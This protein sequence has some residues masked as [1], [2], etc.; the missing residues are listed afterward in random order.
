LISKEPRAFDLQDLLTDSARAFCAQGR[1]R[2]RQCE[3][4]LCDPIGSVPKNVA[5][6]D[7]VPGD[8][9]YAHGF[10]ALD[11]GSGGLGAFCGGACADDCRYGTGAVQGVIEDGHA[12]VLVDVISMAS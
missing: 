4:R 1:R 11:V 2:V 6:R 8:A 9:A 7:K 10:D 5:F 3:Q 12:S